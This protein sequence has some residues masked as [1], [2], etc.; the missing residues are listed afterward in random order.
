MT[1][2]S[3][4]RASRRSVLKAAAASCG[5]M[6]HTSVM[7]TILNLQATKAAAAT[8]DTSG[9]KALVCLFLFGGN[10][11]YNMLVPRNSAS[12]SNANEYDDYASARGGY[13]DGNNNEGGLAL[14]ES[15]LLA[16]NNP[17]NAM[18]RS[19]GLH[20]GFGHSARTYDD[21][22]NLVDDG[23]KELEGGIAKLYQDGKVS[24]LANV[25]SLI[26][27]TTRADYNNQA[28]LPLGLFSH[29]DLQRHW[30]TGAPHTRSQITGWGGRM[31]DLLQSSN[32][33]PSVSM[34][35]SLGGV[36]MFQTGGSVIP[37][38]I[39]Q[40]GATQVSYYNNS[41]IQNRMFKKYVDSMLDQTYS[42]LLAKSFAES[43]RGSID[44]A[45][46]FNTQVNKVTLDTNFDPD[47]LSQRMKRIAQVIGASSDLNQSRQ[48][49]FVSIG[50]FDNHSNLL[51]AQENLLPQVSRALKS[52]YDATVELNCQ[53]DVLTFTA[54]DFGRTLGTNGQ[55]S[56]HAWG[57]VQ[58]LM[59]GGLKGGRMFGDFPLSL[60]DPIHPD[61]GNLN[62]G[63]G[64][65]IPTTSVDEMAAEMAM[66]F[67]VNNAADLKTVLP[68]IESFYQYNANTPPLGF[69]L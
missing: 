68:N 45:I 65:L 3:D 15:D 25:G 48:V 27:P 8:A 26:E 47:S 56:D 10:D 61:V 49:F 35:I 59:G 7:S 43:H 62:L 58:C 16:I 19:F 11:A 37:Y 53:D 13:D 66:W 44:A 18:D 6:T 21:N 52:F 69:I 32:L 50:G 63:R 42:D 4:A 14:R 22:G 34:N 23:N 33:N 5:M 2:E 46:D 54:S 38:A 40:N 1:Y 17:L 31:S 36:N 41:N 60:K 55:G 12:S 57:A 64:R 24:F 29:A 51:G 9:Y 67:G 28:N 39:G 20:P 30:M